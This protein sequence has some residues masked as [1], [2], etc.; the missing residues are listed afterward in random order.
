M[1][2]LADLTT[3]FG[4]AALVGCLVVWP[5]AGIVIGSARPTA[6]E[7]M[8]FLVPLIVLIGIVVPVGTWLALAALRVR[9]AA[10]VATCGYLLSLVFALGAHGLM[11]G[12]AIGPS[13]MYGLCAALGYGAATLTMQPRRSRVADEASPR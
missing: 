7:S 9:P 3:R 4:K 6:R 11:S 12:G 13:C 8:P 5:C 1:T 2:G 10:A